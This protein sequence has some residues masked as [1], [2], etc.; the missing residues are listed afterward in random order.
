MKKLKKSFSKIRRKVWNKPFKPKLPEI[1]S[2]FN[3]EIKDQQ[4][5]FFLSFLIFLIISSIYSYFYVEHKMEAESLAEVYVAKKDFKFPHIIETGDFY[6]EKFQK[7]KLPQGFYTPESKEKL[8]GQALIKNIFAQEIILPHHTQ[9]DLNPESVSAKFEGEFALSMDE[10]W[11]EAKFPDIKPQDLID[12]LV[13]N[14]EENLDETITIASSMKVIEI[15]KEKSKK[16]L[17]INATEVESR[18]ILF[19][20]GLK[21]PMQIIVRSGIKN[22]NLEEKSEENN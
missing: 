12:I 9:P 16:T 10:N 2:P 14:P 19:S 7:Q 13:S 4:K 5:K 11:F 18:A 1:S 3:Q 8:I 15:Q 21:L 6:L 17:I 20:R 22:K